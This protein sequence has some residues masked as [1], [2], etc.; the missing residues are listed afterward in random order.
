MS[1]I[2]YTDKYIFLNVHNKVPVHNVMPLALRGQ[3]IGKYII[4]VIS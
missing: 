1:V 2:A 4:I 3:Y